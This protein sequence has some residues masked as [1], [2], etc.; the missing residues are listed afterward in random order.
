[1]GH[2]KI[3]ALCNLSRL[4]GR[5]STFLGVAK[6]PCFIVVVLGIGCSV[7]Q[8]AAAALQVSYP[9]VLKITAL[10]TDKRLGCKTRFLIY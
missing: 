10:F 6:S 3:E 7:S 2:T 4:F 1:M 8:A 5:A 9:A